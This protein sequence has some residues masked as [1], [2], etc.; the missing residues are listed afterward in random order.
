MTQVFTEN[1][2]AVPVTVIEAGPCHVLQVRTGA[3][4]LGFGARRRNRRATKAALGHAKTAGL[5][6]AP[7]IIRAFAIAGRCAGG[8]RRGQGRHLRA[9]A[10]S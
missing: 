10:S 2:D 1:G 3:V 8:W 5:T 4:Q 9:P 7:A 6:A